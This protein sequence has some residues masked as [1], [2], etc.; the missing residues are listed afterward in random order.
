MFYAR[1]VLVCCSVHDLV[2]L[3]Y[4]LACLSKGCCMGFEYDTAW[5]AQCLGD[6]ICLV[7]AACSNQYCLHGMLI[8]TLP[9]VQS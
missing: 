2:P 7:S 6:R 1:V 3:P 5:H 9:A 8:A 4:A